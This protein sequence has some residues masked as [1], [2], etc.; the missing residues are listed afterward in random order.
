M[1]VVCLGSGLSLI[2]EPGRRHTTITTLA[3][4]A[5]RA[6]RGRRGAKWSLLV[7]CQQ[8]QGFNK[9]LAET[10]PITTSQGKLGEEAIS[11]ST[12]Q[13]RSSL[14]SSSA[15]KESSVWPNGSTRTQK[16]Y[17]LKKSTPAQKRFLIIK[18]FSVQ[19]E[20]MVFLS[21]Q[22]EADPRCDFSCS[23][24]RSRHIISL[25]F[26][27]FIYCLYRAKDVLVHR[28]QGRP[29][30]CLQTICQVLSLYA[31]LY[32]LKMYETNFLLSDLMPGVTLLWHMKWQ[33]LRLNSVFS[34]FFC[35][36]IESGD[37]ELL[38]LEIIHHFVEVRLVSLYMFRHIYILM[39]HD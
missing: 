3:S 19:F 38:T 4:R 20:L 15:G 39:G 32:I 24:A 9:D 16:R 23:G 1:F 2:S 30:D 13:W 27:T 37:N 14:S 5:N 25:Y 36:A 6:N 21:G 29:Q 7:D 35:C 31:N 33:M 17:F 8:Q 18:F 11:F 26:S 12:L 22:E 28:V 10:I 34:L